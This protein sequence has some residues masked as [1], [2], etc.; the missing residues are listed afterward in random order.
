MD[1]TGVS[2]RMQKL[3]FEVFILSFDFT[4]SDR[5]SAGCGLSGLQFYALRDQQSIL[6]RWARRLPADAIFDP[7]VA[8]LERQ[9]VVISLATS[10]EDITIE[11]G[12]VTGARLVESKPIAAPAVAI[13]IPANATSAAAAVV[14]A[15]G[16][17]TQTTVSEF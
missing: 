1:Y 4:T 2:P 13:S 17:V 16:G 9:G 11:N 10:V 6:P 7:I 5:V 3:L 8:Q 12:R 15:A 14:S